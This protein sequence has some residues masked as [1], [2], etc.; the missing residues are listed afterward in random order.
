MI[1][2]T[3]MIWAFVTC[4]I[5]S[6]AQDIQYA[7]SVIDTLCSDYMSG[8]GYVNEG[9][10]RAAAYIAGEMTGMG[11]NVFNINYYQTVTFPI[12]TI[13]GETKVV[14]DG[15]TLEAGTDYLIAAHCKATKRSFEIVWLDYKVAKSKRRLK[16]FINKGL[17]DKI[18]LIDPKISS[19][20]KTRA[21]TRSLRF[22]N[23]LEAAGVIISSEKLT[24]HI[25]D[26]NKVSDYLVINIRNGLLTEKS[27]EITLDFNNRFY[28]KYHSQNVI[29]YIPGTKNPDRYIVFTGHYDHLGM[30]GNV[31][32]PGANDNASGIAMMLDLAQYYTKNPPEYSIVFMAFTGEEAGLHGSTT[33][34]ENPYFNLDDIQILFNLDMVGTGSDGIMVVN[35]SKFEEEFKLL[36]SLNTESG[37]LKKVGKRGESRNSDHYPFYAKGVTAFF[38]YT[39]G[40]EFHVYH[41]TSDKAKDIPLTDYEDLVGLLIRFVDSYTSIHE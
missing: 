14:L 26:G 27:K 33:Y 39:R 30:M 28:E 17:K 15:N 19:S 31:M 21:F 18:V 12:N 23:T 3:I 38:I 35:G 16:K 25:V 29:G 11:L 41:S 7:R 37:L 10:K 20:E 9:D 40:K 32:F 36:D 2:R 8:R 6:Q 4:F 13:L 22:S 5:T 34:A 1:I 24:W